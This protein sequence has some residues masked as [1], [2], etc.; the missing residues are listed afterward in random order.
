VGNFPVGQREGRL[1]ERCPPLSRNRLPKGRVFICAVKDTGSRIVFRRSV[2][3]AKLIW[4]DT[5]VVDGR[6]PDHHEHESKTAIVYYLVTPGF[7]LADGKP[8]A[9]SSRSFSCV[10]SASIL[11]GKSCKTL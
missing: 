2:E 7:K 6:P 3:I 11:G 1:L 5:G 9:Y 4:T 8:A 10:K